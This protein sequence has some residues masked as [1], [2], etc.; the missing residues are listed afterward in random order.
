MHTLLHDADAALRALKPI[1][2]QHPER[3]LEFQQTGNVDAWEAHLIQLGMH[4]LEVEH[5][6]TEYNDQR[7]NC[8]NWNGQACGKCEGCEYLRVRS[9]ADEEWRDHNSLRRNR[10]GSRSALRRGSYHHATW[11]AAKSKE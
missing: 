8:E 4:L 7:S 5:L 11:L 10:V 1:L 6:R 9:A 3:W 2:R